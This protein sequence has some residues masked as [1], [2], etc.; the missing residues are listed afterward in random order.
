MQQ[1]GDR[2]LSSFGFGVASELEASFFKETSFL[3]FFSETSA[4]CFFLF[5]RFGDATGWEQGEEVAFL[6]ATAGLEV[7]GGAADRKTQEKLVEV[8]GK[9]KK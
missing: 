9:M 4:S 8:L 3:L 1:I 7:A 2:R 5:S 6:S